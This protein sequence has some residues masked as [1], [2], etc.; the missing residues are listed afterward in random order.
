MMRVDDVPERRVD[1]GGVEIAYWIHGEGAPLVLITGL[2]SPASAWGPL[3]GFLGQMGYQGVVVENRDVGKSSP[4]DGIDY[5]IIDMANDVATVMADA[6]IDSAYVLGISMGGMIAQELALNHPEKVKKLMLLATTPG[7]PEGVS[8]TPEFLA[9]L[10]AIATDGDR[11][12]WTIKMAHSLVGK[13]VV[14]ERPERLDAWA[15]SRIEEGPSA[16]GYQRQ[17]QAIM[18]FGTWDRLPELKIPTLILHGTDDPLLPFQNGEKL[19]SR[20]PNADFM[21]LEGVGHLIPLEVPEETVNAIVRFFPVE[22]PV[23][24]P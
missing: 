21:P 5:T 1:C 8:A 6:G 14:E 24:T 20:I 11:R 3:P 23:T 15:T 19:A 2:A 17:L 18:Q 9:Q 7:R 16:D 22:A 10:A 4:C 13:K 12:T